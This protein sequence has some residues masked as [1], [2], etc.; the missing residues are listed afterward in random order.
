[1]TGHA[2]VAAL[3]V[4]VGALLM[5]GGCAG[6]EA[7]FGLPTLDDQD[8][9]SAIG[10]S[11]SAAQPRSGHLL[12]ES[13][14]CFTWRADNATRPE[15]GAWIVWPA[16]ARQDADVVVLGSGERIAD[17]AALDAVGASVDLGDLPEGAN[18]DSYFGSFGGFC[19]AAERGVLVLTSVD[20]R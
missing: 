19:D 9:G 3:L 18:A 7:G 4:G 13:N 14:G 10:A 16:D 5:L 1:M 12:V 15:D 8:A 20:G 6:S 2:R 17:G 11:G